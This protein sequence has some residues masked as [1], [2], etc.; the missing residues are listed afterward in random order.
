M[1]VLALDLSL[2]ATGWALLDAKDDHVG[3]RRPDLPHGTIKTPGRRK[4]EDEWSWYARRSYVFT[5]ELSY[6]LVH[7]RPD[8]LVIEVS[9]RVF[10]RK[11]EEATSGRYGAGVQ[12]RAAQGL[13][14]VMGWVDTVLASQ[15]EPPVVVSSDIA[16]AKRAITGYGQATKDAVR[17]FLEGI[18]GWKLTG[19]TDDEVD[20]LSIAVAHLQNLQN[21]ARD[22]A[23][24]L[25]EVVVGPQGESLVART[26]SRPPRSSSRRR[27]I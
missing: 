11:G 26:R 16:V 22:R 4:D 8:V 7:H 1:R 9:K 3:P 2:A 13:G 23:R 21:D 20:A 18:Y 25:A 17:S 6:L 19:W 12:Y 27:T 5:G 10:S 24:A 14:R 15:V